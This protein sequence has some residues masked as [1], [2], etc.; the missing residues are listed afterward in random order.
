MLDSISSGH[1]AYS[2]LNFHQAFSLEITAG[3]EVENGEGGSATVVDRITIRRETSFALTYSGVLPI[4]VDEEAGYRKL[5]DLVTNLLKEQGIAT[6]VDTGDATV[7]LAALTPGTARELVAED[8]YFGVEKTSDRIVEFAKT[9]AGGDPSRID[10]IRE[11]ISRGFDEA[12]KA[13]GGRL[14]DISRE[15]YDA[16]MDKLDQW[17]SE[18]K[19]AA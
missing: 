14:P 2:T 1:Q 16:V 8:G 19:A 7:D 17:V 4:E 3:R 15:T 9:T 18:A 6:T 12:R 13:F 5:Q 10:A 11:G